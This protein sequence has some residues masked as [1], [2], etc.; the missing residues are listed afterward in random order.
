MVNTLTEMI[1]NKQINFSIDPIDDCLV[2]RETVETKKI[3][4][5]RQSVRTIE[6]FIRNKHEDLLR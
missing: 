4:V 3:E 6:Q 5:Y 1:R 2:Q